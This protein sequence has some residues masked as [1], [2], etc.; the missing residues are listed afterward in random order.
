MIPAHASSSTRPIHP[1]RRPRLAAAIALAAS[2]LATTFATAQTP[3]FTLLGVPSPNEQSYGNALS[4]DGRTVVGYSSG[5]QTRSFIWTA[6]TGRVDL[7]T[8]PSLNRA[9]AVN[10]DGSI[11]G[12]FWQDPGTL[13]P[14]AYR[15]TNGT[16]QTLTEPQGYV[17]SNITGMS[18]DGSVMAGRL[19]TAPFG[20][21]RVARWRV[22]SGWQDLGVPNPS[23][24]VASF[25]TGISGDGRTIVGFGQDSEALQDAAAW[26]EGSGWRLLPLPD[27]IGVSR[28]SGAGGVNSDGSIIVGSVTPPASRSLATIWRS[29]QVE[30]LATLG[31][32]WAM[33]AGVVSNDG[34]V[35]AGTSTFQGDRRF[36]TVWTSPGRVMLLS[37]Y[38]LQFNIQLPPNTRLEQ[39]T[40]IS[41]DGRNFAGTAF[42]NNLRQ[43]FIATV[44][45]PGGLVLLAISGVLAARRNRGN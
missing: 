9:T 30:V 15:Y 2:A 26:T 39:V 1:A 23:R 34:S 7:P 44:P 43:A 31:S 10:A 33:S 36:A 45:A 6:A 42:I 19:G 4:A 27:G 29:G 13:R 18:A 20:A 38:L 14:R 32:D 17:D 5:F 28:G 40:G 41:P 25:S 3:S 12:G 37:D 21:S 22:G 35:I 16:L 11:V 8:S 24:H